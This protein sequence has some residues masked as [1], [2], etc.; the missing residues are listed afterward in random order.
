MLEKYKETQPL[1]YRILKNALKNKKYAHAYIFEDPFLTSANE[2]VIDFIK[3]ILTIDV[4]AFEK[5]KIILM[6]DSDNH[7]ELKKISSE[8]M[9]IKKEQIKDLQEEFNKKPIYGDKKIYIIEEAEKLNKSSANTILKFLEEPEE[10]IFAFLLTK[11]TEQ[12]LETIRS[13]CQLVRIIN[14]NQSNNLETIAL[15]N[16]I[17]LNELIEK[18]KAIIDFVHFYEKR[19]LEIICYMQKMWHNIFN[20]KELALLGYDLLL[21]YYK[22]VL[23]IKIGKEKLYFLE[24]DQMEDIFKFQEKNEISKKLKTI[25][26]LK[27]KIRLNAN[28]NLL[29][30]KLVIELEEEVI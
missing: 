14:N 13:R 25:A 21:Y 23:N 20:T 12:I 27:E 19:H 3:E 7:P 10:G 9:W 17:E 2:I 11:N 6:I 18:K 22:D 15:V 24:D 30:D 28:L 26:L 1:A 29:M 4:D 5:E 8:T 16:N